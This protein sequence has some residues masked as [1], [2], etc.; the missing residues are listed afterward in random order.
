MQHFVQLIQTLTSTSNFAS[1]QKALVTYFNK[2]NDTDKVWCLALLM[3]KRP[4]RIVATSQLRTWAETRTKYP[5]WLFDST[6]RQVGDMLETITK[7]VPKPKRIVSSRTLTDWVESILQL[8]LESDQ[9]LRQVVYSHWEELK[10]EERL[11]YNKL[12][13]G[14][15]RLVINPKL[16]AEALSE[17]LKQDFHAVMY[18]LM[19]EWEPSGITFDELL[20]DNKQNYENSKPYPYYL[21]KQIEQPVEQLGEVSGWLAEYK[22]DGIRC[23]VIKR[24][25]QA[26]VWTREEELITHLLPE[27]LTVE[28]TSCDFVLDGDLVAFKDGILP[29]EAIQKRLSRKKLTKK[30]L[31]EMPI[32]YIAYDILELDGEDLRSI[33]QSERRAKLENLVKEINQ[34]II[35][36]SDFIDFDS[37]ANLDAIKEAARDKSATG[38]MIKSR[39][40]TYKEGRESSDWYKWNIAP[41]SMEAVMLYAHRNSMRSRVYQEFTFALIDETIPLGEKRLVVITKAQGDLD[42]DELKEISKFIKDNTVERFGPVISI[43]PNLVFELSFQDVTLSTKT[44]SGLA[45]KKPRIVRWK[46]DKLPTEINTIQELKEHIKN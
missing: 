36:L 15:F 24:L 13:T 34:P 4:K 27:I 33:S 7:M 17:Y 35:S 44:K 26:Y 43:H 40:G 21:G 8:G 42:L 18:K 32:M 19:I 11:L 39:S 37:W 14:G 46:K 31:N 25:G 29:L 5:T 45:L 10:L 41:F 1:R 6:F 38:L 12:L 30:L 16:L 20:L 28:N 2:A 9:A 23:Q 22:W 3:G